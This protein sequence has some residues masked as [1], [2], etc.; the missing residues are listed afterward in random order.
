MLVICQKVLINLS[1]IINQKFEFSLI[2]F[3]QIFLRFNVISL[4]GSTS[5]ALS[6]HTIASLDSFSRTRAIPCGP[7]DPR[8]AR[9]LRAGPG[10]R[11]P[12]PDPLPATS[13]ALPWW[14][15]PTSLPHSLTPGAPAARPAAD[16]RPNAQ[17][18]PRA[19]V[20]LPGQQKKSRLSMPTPAAICGDYTPNG[21]PGPY[22]RSGV[23]GP[24][25]SSPPAERVTIRYACQGN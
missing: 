1:A 8:A 25:A 20:A 17:T 19:A 2:A 15:A 16:P 3:S 22:R 10:P 23:A 6:N 12:G 9:G 21:G 24:F 5:S 11:S 13:L 4:V 14:F 7:A 18:R